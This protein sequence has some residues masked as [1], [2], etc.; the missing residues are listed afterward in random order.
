MGWWGSG[1]WGGGE[2][3][4]GLGWENGGDWRT[5]NVGMLASCGIDVGLPEM[6]GVLSGF[7]KVL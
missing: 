2:S 7:N 5:C 3:G 6:V 1:R 4:F